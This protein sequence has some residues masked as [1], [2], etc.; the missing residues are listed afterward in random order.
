MP[1]QIMGVLNITPDSFSDGGKFLNPESAIAHAKKMIE[2]GADILDLGAESSRPGATPV[3]PEEELSRLLP[4]LTALKAETKAVISVDTTKPSVAEE[5]LKLG[6]SIINDITGLENPKMA[7]TIA[8]YDATLIIMHMQ[9]KPQTMQENPQYNN[10]VEEIKTFFEERIKRAKDAGITKI[11][12]DPGIGFGKTLEHNLTILNNIQS[13]KELGYPILIGASR[14]S[15]I[16]KIIPNLQPENRLEGTLAAN[17]IAQYNG[18]DILRVHDVLA[19]K[20]AAQVAD[21]IQ[22]NLGGK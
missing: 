11:V 18:V 13:F 22:N 10:V 8:K 15:F 20:R 21:A 7:Q 14:K 1:T 6:V 9:G 16:E 3:N 19:C 17:T 4:V 5:C 2:E 12:L